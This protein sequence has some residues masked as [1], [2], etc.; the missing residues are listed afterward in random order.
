MDKESEQ[1]LSTL[2]DEV[3][4]QSYAEVRDELLREAKRAW[5]EDEQEASLLSGLAIS[6]PVPA[7]R[8]Y[9]AACIRGARTAR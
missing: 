5:K 3:N 8:H 4:K 7:Q 2:E 1:L 9:T 6:E